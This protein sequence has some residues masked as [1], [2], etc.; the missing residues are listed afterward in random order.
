M[1]HDAIG[2]PGCTWSEDYPNEDDTMGDFERNDLFCLKKDDGEII[3]AIS[4]D[5]DDK[6]ESLPCWDAAPRPSAELSR[7]VVKEKYQNQG[8]ARQLLTYGMQELAKRGYKSVH[9]LVSKTN[10]R[11]LRSYAKFNFNNRGESDLYD[12]HWLCYEKELQQDT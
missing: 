10:E 2:S 7:L 3:G 4:I 1:Y 9:F 8:I 12:E 6:V 5:K 11:A